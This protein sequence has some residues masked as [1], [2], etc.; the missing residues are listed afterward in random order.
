MHLVECHSI[1][2]QSFVL[3]LLCA[4]YLSPPSLFFTGKRKRAD[5]LL[6]T[7]QDMFVSDAEQQ[8]QGDACF[9]SMLQFFQ[10]QAEREAEERMALRA[11]LAEASRQQRN[12]ME[13]LLGVMDRMPARLETP[14]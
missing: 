3:Q 1:R 8:R 11:E 13:A 10:E 7:V 12:L 2:I 6:T 14:K 4:K 9:D 5:T